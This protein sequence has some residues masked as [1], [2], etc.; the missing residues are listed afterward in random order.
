VPGS[1]TSRSS[2]LSGVVAGGGPS[3]DV[4]RECKHPATTICGRICVTEASAPAWNWRDDG[5]APGVVAA[6]IGQVV[7][8]WWQQAD[9][10][11]LRRQRSS[12]ATAWTIIASSSAVVPSGVLPFTLMRSGVLASAPASH[13]RNRV[14]EATIFGRW[15]M[16]TSSIAEPPARGLHARERVAQERE[17]VGILPGVTGLRSVSAGMVGQPA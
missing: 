10:S 12:N 6:A 2:Q 4:R 3:N 9:R 5:I 16:T 17:A 7:D 8:R 1:Q 11:I 15:Q 13:A 14:R